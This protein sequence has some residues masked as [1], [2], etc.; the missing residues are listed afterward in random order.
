MM[1]CRFA[2]EGAEG[3]GRVLGLLDLDALHVEG[4]G[5][6][7]DDE[8][9]HDHRDDGADDDVLTVYLYFSRVSPF[10]MTED[11]M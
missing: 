9:G 11:C 3:D 7:H 8:E 1:V 10:S 5:A 2:R 6:G 4:G